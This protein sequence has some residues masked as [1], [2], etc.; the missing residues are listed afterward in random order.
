MSKSTFVMLNHHSAWV[1]AGESGLQPTLNSLHTVDMSGATTVE[2]QAAAILAGLTKHRLGKKNLVLVLGPQHAEYRPFQVPPVGPAELPTIVHNLAMTQMTKIGENSIIDFVAMP[3]SSSGSSSGSGNS[4]GG[5]K[6]FVSATSFQASLLMEELQ[7]RGVTFERILPRVVLPNLL[8]TS[9]GSDVQVM[10]NVLGSEID[11]VATQSNQL[12]MVRSSVLPSEGEDRQKLIGRET[13]RSLAVLAAEFGRTEKMDIVVTGEVGDAQSVVDNIVAQELEAKRVPASD[14]GH[15]TSGVE[16]VDS[17]YAVLALAALRMDRKPLLDF[18]NPTLPPED[19]AIKRKLMLI[20]ALAATVVLGLVGYAWLEIRG[21][22]RQ[23]ADL[24]FEVKRLEVSEADNDSIITRVGMLNSF[25]TMD[26]DPL[27]LLELLSEQLPYGEQLRVERLNLEPQPATTTDESEDF[28][29]TMT[30][31]L[32]DRDLQFKPKLTSNKGWVFSAIPVVTVLT[33]SQY[34]E[35]SAREIFTVP[36]DFKAIYERLAD[37]VLGDA[38]NGDEGLDDSESK[39]EAAASAR[40]VNTEQKRVDESDMEAEEA[41]QLDD[42]DDSDDD[43]SD[44]RD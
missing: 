32:Q 1:G 38:E 23:L 22:D 24:S 12:V 10:I 36:R 19:N 42:S 44:E 20:G 6:V 18:A 30:A 3:Q 41:D 7:G 5:L 9:S 39:P 40:L 31:L 26:A 11:F 17:S 37:A 34:Y 8:R 28:Q 29:V 4:A 13:S 16:H 35:R 2:E 43:A 25:V 15:I 14:F 33:K 27:P 21:L